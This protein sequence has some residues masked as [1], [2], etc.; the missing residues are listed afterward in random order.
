MIPRLK[1]QYYKT[2][3]DNLSKKPPPA[4][5]GVRPAGI[6]RDPIEAALEASIE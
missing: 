2:A 4:P 3:V 6:V 1:E 5:V